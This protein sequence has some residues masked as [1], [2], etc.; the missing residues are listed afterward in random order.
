VR[1]QYLTLQ[2]RCDDQ[3]TDGMIMGIGGRSRG[4][5]WGGLVVGGG[6]EATRAAMSSAVKGGYVGES[7]V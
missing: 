4:G 1:A 2:R 7:D 6:E 5:S 3:N